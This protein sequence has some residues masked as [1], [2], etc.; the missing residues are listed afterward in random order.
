MRFFFTLAM[1]VICFQTAHANPCDQPIQ[2]SKVDN[3]IYLQ[4]RLCPGDGKKF[5]QY[6]SG[7]GKGVSLIRL[8]SGGGNGAD[9]VEIGRYIRANK[10]TTWTD[11]RQ[12]KCASACNRVFAGG[13]QRIYSHA[14]YIQTGK[15]PKQQ[16]GL[17]YHHPNVNGDFHAAED[18]YQKGI[19]PYLKD[20]LPTKAFNWVYQTDVGNMTPNMVWLNGAQALE[21]GVATSTQAPR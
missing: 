9:A 1:F 10:M 14:N 17:G 4:G 12:D 16:F 21:L 2:L 7:P 19:V 3:Y 15:I 6:M 13:V 11:G 20:M 5:I 18:W 8:S